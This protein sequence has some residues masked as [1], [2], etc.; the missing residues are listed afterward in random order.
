MKLR[1]KGDSIRLRLTKSEVDAIGQ[2]NTVTETTRLPGPNL[3][4]Y[5]LVPT[6]EVRDLRADF[7]FGHLLV[8][9]PAQTA[10]GWAR[11]EEVAM[12]ANQP[13]A[14][15][16]SSQLFILVEKDFACLKPREVHEDESDMFE[17]PNSAK[18]CCG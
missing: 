13:I 3:L 6:F 10:R 14:N 5:S 12:Q 8:R 2:G 18:G 1:I 4:Q 16:V 15:E 9:V 17:N 11:S 7:E